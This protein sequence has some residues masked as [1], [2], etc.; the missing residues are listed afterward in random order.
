MRFPVWLIA[1][2]LVA[3][4]SSPVL[5]GETTYTNA[6]GQ[7]VGKKDAAG[8]VTNAKGQVR[9]KEDEKGRVYDRKGRYKG[10]VGNGNAQK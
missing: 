8:R 2:A 9:V 1:A 6:K 5:A 10:Q 3:A 4:F 7:Y